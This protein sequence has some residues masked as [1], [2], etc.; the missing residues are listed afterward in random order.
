MTYK[1]FCAISGKYSI[2]VI[3]FAFKKLMTSQHALFVL[4][5]AL[6]L[7]VSKVD[8]F[9]HLAVCICL[10]VEQQYMLI[11]LCIMHYSVCQLQ[12]D[13]EQKVTGKSRI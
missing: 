2:V 13:R 1:N 12:S 5:I 4:F 3:K 9:V 11:A 10:V 8:K 7:H 6:V